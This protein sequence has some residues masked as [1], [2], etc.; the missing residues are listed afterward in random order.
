MPIPITS[1]PPECAT[2]ADTCFH[3]VLVN[4]EIPPNTGSIARLCAGTRCRL[5]LVKPLGFELDDRRLKRAG[6]DY[7]PAVDLS[8][9]ESFEAIVALFGPQR[10]HLFTTK[11]EKVYSSVRF[12]LGDAL[13]FGAETKGLATEIRERYPERCVILPIAK[14]SIRSLNLAN[15][16]SIGL[17]EALRQVDF[18]P[19]GFSNNAREEVVH[20][21]Y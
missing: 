5:H 10:L 18:A 6:L 20:V 16:V 2:E 17:F 12:R 13:V 14:G 7:W 4:P 21:T 15:S 3:V 8:V 1:P 9:H 19:I 11:A